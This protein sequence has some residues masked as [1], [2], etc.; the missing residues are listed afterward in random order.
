MLWI[1]QKHYKLI[2]VNLSRQKEF[3]ADAKAIQR[4]EFVAQLK[5][6]NSESAYGTQNTF[7]LIIWKTFKKTQQDSLKDM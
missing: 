4:T 6:V 2:A 3:D 1:Y 5:N 7:V